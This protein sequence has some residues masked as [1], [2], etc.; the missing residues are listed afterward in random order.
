MGQKDG[1]KWTAEASLQPTIPK[2]DRLLGFF[3]RFLGENVTPE[4]CSIE[5]DMPNPGDA[6]QPPSN[7]AP[8]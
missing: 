6:S 8:S 3:A 4:D 5:T 7:P 2:S 1:G